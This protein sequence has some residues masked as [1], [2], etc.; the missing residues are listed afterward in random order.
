MF[1]PQ[2]GNYM[3][4]KAY[5]I[6][7][8]YS[9]FISIYGAYINVRIIPTIIFACLFIHQPQSSSQQKHCYEITNI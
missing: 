5:K 9:I 7:F 6:D 1:Q 8:S 2:K 3:T 4:F